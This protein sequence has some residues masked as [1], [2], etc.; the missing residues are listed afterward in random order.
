MPIKPMAHQLESLK[1]C[2]SRKRVADLSDAGCVSA[3]T[4]F[5]TTKGW[6]RIDQYVKGDNVAQFHPDTREIEFVTPIDY[7]KRPCTSMIAISPCRGTSQRLSHEHR[8]LY[9]RKDG[10]Y[11]VTSAREFMNICHQKTPSHFDGKFC[12]TFSI[13]THNVLDLSDIDI[14]V[15][16][17]VIADGHFPNNGNRC[18]IRIKKQRKIE[19]LC[20]LLI[21]ANI[22]YKEKTCGGKPDFQVFTFDAPRH[23]KEFTEY[24]WKAAQFQLEIIADELPH[25]DASAD[26]RP[27]A[28]TRFSTFIESTANFAQYAFSATKRPASITTSCRD[29]TNEGRGLMLE[30][31]VH[32]Q[33]KDKLIGPGRR[34]SI[35]EISNPEGFKYC[36]EVP[37]SFL[38]LRHNGY[39]F[40][41]GNTGKTL[42]QILDFAQQHKKDSK[43]MLV[44]APKSLLKAAWAND[45]RKFAPHLKV[46]IAWAN[47]R[48]EAFAAKADVY[49]TNIDA[50]T[51]LLKYPKTAWKDFG[52][53]VVD[54]STAYKNPTSKR[55]KAVAK[56]AKHFEWRR[57]M[58]GTPMPQG[59]CDLWHQIYILDEG[60]RLGSSYYNFRSSCCAPVQNGPSTQHIKWED[61][62][63]IGDAVVGLLSDIII[64][65]RFEDCVDI[66]PNHQYSVEVELNPKH[67]K[68]YRDFENMQLAEIEG[69]TITAINAAALNTKL[70]QVASGA[71][72]NDHGSYSLI[73]TDRYELVAELVEAR[74]HSTVWYQWKHQLD[75]TIKALKAR[76]IAYVVWNPDHPE[77]EQEFQAG[78]YQAILCHPASA[79]HGLTF[80]RAIA[81][82]LCSPTYNLEHFLQLYKRIYRIGQKEKTETIVVV[83]PGTRDEHAWS[84]MLDKRVRQDDF[85]SAVHA[86]RPTKRVT[87]KTKSVENS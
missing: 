53:L 38:L 19:R 17:A 33:A 69:K 12:S 81:S 62:P 71:V 20:N 64:R 82:I 54:E 68:F 9:Y 3:D 83:A 49:I 75:E 18:V 24:W 85:F 50:V 2:K 52:R 35:F 31:V 32:A 10:S 60:K 1:F 7:I 56:L 58:T 39:I 29:R 8:V 55:S 30:Y 72:Y 76:K 44:L 80:T 84:R 14:R 86:A 27:S 51:D 22:Q 78:R 40:A 74:S 21:Q 16:V 37:T 13:R 23:D 43:A 61:K 66:P 77:I 15:M 42:V 47:N 11:G 46:S 48:K 65:H 26:K 28:G 25:W 34:E 59:V 87:T 5:L 45:I 70:L 41:T 73:D 57:V 67:E 6:K 36:F 63:G 79:G 4:E